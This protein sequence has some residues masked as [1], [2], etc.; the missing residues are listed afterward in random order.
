MV[1]IG[2]RQAARRRRHST[3]VIHLYNNQILVA[4]RAAGG[5]NSLAFVERRVG[6]GAST[7]TMC[8][9]LPMFPTDGL[10]TKAPP[11]IAVSVTLHIQG[12]LSAVV[13]GWG[14]VVG[15]WGSKSVIIWR[16]LSA[17]R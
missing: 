15:G 13:R 10:T 2:G 17:R 3:I 9:A 11:S 5:G 16:L 12:I 8:R 6:V 1:V 7:M 14:V 4:S